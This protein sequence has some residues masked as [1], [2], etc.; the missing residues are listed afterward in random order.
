M[1]CP[2]CK[3][4]ATKRGFYIRPSDRKSIQRFHCKPCQ[5][6]FSTQTLNIDYRLRKRQFNQMIFRLLCS[7]QSQRRC[8]LIFHLKP[9]AIARRV[10]RFAAVAESNLSIYRSQRSKVHTFYFDEMES[11]E[12]TKCKPVTIPIAVEE[13]T[14]KILAFDVGKIAAKGKLAAISRKKYGQRFCQRR[15]VLQNVFSDLRQCSL[16]LVHIKSDE[17]VHYPALIKKN[18]ANS[19]HTGF[20][21]VRGCVTG[22]GELKAKKFD[23]LFSLNHT[24]AMVRDNIKTL[25]R[26]T[27]CTAKTIDELKQLL[28]IYAW[29]HNMYLDNPKKIYLRSLAITI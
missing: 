19:T 1:T 9:I 14:R 8:A 24:Y 28:Y 15:L 12:H 13:Q 7:G 17:S 26:R 25:S 4:L 29:F 5:K 27:W 22:Q 16:D 3:G 18:F 23:P 6:S 20:K 21:G 2:D 11:F 10:S